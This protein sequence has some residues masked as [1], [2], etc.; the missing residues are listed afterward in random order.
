MPRNYIRVR[1]MEMP[2]E[3]A[4]RQAVY[5][6]HSKQLSISA[7]AKKFEL[8]KSTAAQYCQIHTLQSLVTE[9]KPMKRPQHSSTQIF[10][11]Q[12][13]GELSQYLMLSVSV[14]MLS[15]KPW[16]NTWWYSQ[17]SL[18]V[19]FCQWCNFPSQLDSSNGCFKGLVY[20]IHET[21]PNP[22]F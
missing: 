7:A 18:S 9:L 8:T 21:K 3:I 13:E 4:I 16:F 11:S 17:A 5:A 20:R 15:F 1:K 12:Q 10:T 19:C 2:S 14:N 22:L 6:V